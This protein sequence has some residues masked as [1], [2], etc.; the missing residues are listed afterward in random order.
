LVIGYDEYFPTLRRPQLY[1]DAVIRG[2]T[3]SCRDPGAKGSCGAEVAL[4][5][6]WR[7]LAYSQWAIRNPEDSY[8]T[9][10]TSLVPLSLVQST[11]GVAR[12]AQRRI[13]SSW[14]SGC[15]R[16]YEKRAFWRSEQATRLQLFCRCSV[17]SSDSSSWST[18]C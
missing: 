5:R 14:Q 17:G 11:S 15:I 4:G 7:W 6:W 2:R 16:R 18:K 3:F 12:M 8:S 9:S 10:D 13:C 1:V